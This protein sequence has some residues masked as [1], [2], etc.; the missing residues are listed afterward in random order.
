M[1]RVA[2]L[3]G[4]ALA[5]VTLSLRVTG[6]RPD[7]YH[8]LEALAVS[9]TAPADLVYFNRRRRPGVRITVSP[10]GA[11]PEDAS[12]L[13]VRAVAS[14]APDLSL[15]GGLRV[16]V[17][18]QVPVGAGLG[19]GSSDAAATLRLLGHI[20]GLPQERLLE[21]AAE[22]GSDVP[23]CLRGTPA[24]M[25][26]RG[27]VLEPVD[28]VPQLMLVIA[29]PGFGCSTPAVYQAYDELG[30]PH[31]TREVPAPASFAHLTPTFGN[32]L[33]LAAEHV[34]PRLRG[35][36][37]R[38]ER[39]IGVPVMLC[40]SGSAYVAWFDSEEAWRSGLDAARRGL[41]SAKVFGGTTV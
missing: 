5:K 7:G 1:R 41:P 21:I 22:L 29:V 40:G 18:K 23:F 36:R 20:A 30:G 24:W 13:V 12:N 6:R 35:F 38:F 25:R 37:E 8:D 9:S 2:W 15:R 39:A 26:G 28:G 34:E 11:A 19:G 33:E 14:L 31:S 10:P 16:R 27:E 32:D 4:A 3:R 17:S